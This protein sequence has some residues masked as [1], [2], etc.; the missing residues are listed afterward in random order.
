MT[1]KTQGEDASLEQNFKRLRW[2]VF[3]SNTIAIRG[4]SSDGTF[5]TAIDRG[6]LFSGGE[7][8]MVVGCLLWVFA[9]VSECL[10]LSCSLKPLVQVI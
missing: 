9:D 6:E 5:F 7:I 3:F 8:R 2:L 1:H 4:L 10:T